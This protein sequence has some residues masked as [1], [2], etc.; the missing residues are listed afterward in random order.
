MLLEKFQ[1]ENLLFTFLVEMIDNKLPVIIK[2][3]KIEKAEESKTLIFNRPIK[4]G[5]N[6]SGLQI[7]K[8]VIDKKV[9]EPKANRF[10]LKLVL[11]YLVKE[12]K[13]NLL[14]DLPYK[15]TDNAKRCLINNSKFHPD[16][17]KMSDILPLLD[18]NDEYFIDTKGSTNSL[19]NLCYELLKKH[20]ISAEKLEI[21]YVK[22]VKK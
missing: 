17:K 9:F 21:H 12:T 19:H 4:K 18:G 13:I 6:L 11:N 1:Y 3:E 16:N 20:N 7:T 14:F 10:L 22:R 8:V 15:A 5:E 2:T